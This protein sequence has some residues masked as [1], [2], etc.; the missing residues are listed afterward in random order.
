MP[1]SRHAQDDQ[2]VV[3]SRPRPSPCP[4]AACSGSRCRS[5]CGR[6]SARSRTGASRSGGTCSISTL[7]RDPCVAAAASR[8]ARPRRSAIASSRDA[9]VQL[10]AGLE[11]GQVEQVGDDPRRAGSASRSS[12]SVKRRAA[13]GS[14]MAPSRSVSAAARI[15]ATGVFSSWE[16]FATKS[17]R[18]AVERVGL[19]DVADHQQDRAAV[20]DGQRGGP[21][22]AGRRSQSRPRSASMP[23]GGAS[24]RTARWRSIGS[25]AS[26]VVG[27]VPRCRPS[28]AFAKS[29][30]SVGSTSR[31]PSSIAS[32]IRPCTSLPSSDDRSVARSSSAVLSMRRCARSSCRRVDAR[33]MSARDQRPGGEREDG[34]AATLSICGRVYGRVPACSS[35][36]PRPFRRHS[37]RAARRPDDPGREGVRVHSRSCPRFGHATCPGYVCRD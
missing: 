17:R 9:L 28:A 21:E 29:R 25:S 8:A 37:P 22:P 10:A 13:G 36:V 7:E 31:T 1:V 18:I 16:A 35:S 4:P 19:G 24:L 14:S 32:R 12:C 5:G 11:P 6:S 2:L 33:T 3:G 30:S 15:E 20:S 23:P 34:R 27:T 26:T